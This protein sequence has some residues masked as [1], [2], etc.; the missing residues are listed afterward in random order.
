MSQKTA[1]LQAKTVG[2]LAAGFVIGLL[3]GLLL[4]PYLSALLLAAPGA[5]T[6]G[7]VDKIKSRGKLIVGTSADWPPFEYIDKNGQLS[8]IHI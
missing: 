2:F 7:Y 1:R 4:G 6:A 3:V 8:L 5:H